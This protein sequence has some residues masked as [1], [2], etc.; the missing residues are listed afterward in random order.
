MRNGIL[1]LLL[2]ILHKYVLEFLLVQDR[3][4]KLIEINEIAN[5][6][7]RAIAEREIGV[8]NILFI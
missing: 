2:A 7:P 6:L 8:T 3:L 4:T 1:H 5:T